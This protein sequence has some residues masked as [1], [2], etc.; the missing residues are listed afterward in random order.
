MRYKGINA[1]I[2]PALDDFNRTYGFKCSNIDPVQALIIRSIV[3]NN[4]MPS[5]DYKLGK[6]ARPFLQGWDDNCIGSWVYVEFW[7]DKDRKSVV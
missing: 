6:K 7:T 1:I 3:L 4:Y 5:E 2:V